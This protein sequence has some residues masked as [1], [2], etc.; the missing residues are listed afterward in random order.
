MIS[1]F[2]N[3]NNVLHLC[4]FYEKYGDSSTQTIRDYFNILNKKALKT[5]FKNKS[6]LELNLIL[7]KIYLY[8]GHHYMDFHYYDRAICLADKCRSL[9]NEMR[10]S[11]FH[12]IE[13]S[14][15]NTRSNY[16]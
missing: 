10:E 15:K 9:C 6:D 4:R 7:S 5:A 1:T 8:L 14:K 2:L 13:V 3:L 12:F 11:T 16:L